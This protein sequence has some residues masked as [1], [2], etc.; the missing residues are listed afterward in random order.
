MKKKL[1]LFII[2]IILIFI[3]LYLI[4]SIFTKKFSP[5]ILEYSKGEIKRI[6]STVINKAI[7]TNITNKLDPNKLFILENREVITVT[8]DP[9][10]VNSISNDAVE[11][12]E[13]MLNDYLK[14]NYFRVPI[15]I[16]FNN[17]LLMNIGPKIPVKFL[18]LGN[19]TS[20]IETEIKEYGINNSVIIISLEIKAEIK[21][22]LPIT[23]DYVS[24][25]NYVP[26][27]IKLIQGNV[28][29]YYNDKNLYPKIN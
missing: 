4:L 26:I 7:D 22:I 10:L 5:F 6:A 21:V 11:A 3:I 28:P 15:G 24:I 20:G 13:I 17:P 16:I 9:V 23:S 2:S 27:S 19:I 14:N 18:L 12:V 25:T 8:L 29:V 1:R